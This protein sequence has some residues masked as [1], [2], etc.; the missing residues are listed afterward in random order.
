MKIK[1]DV[2]FMENGR[3]KLGPVRRATG[4]HGGDV[5]LKG[6]RCGVRA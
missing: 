3:K 6:D 2:A 1:E 5:V 4:L